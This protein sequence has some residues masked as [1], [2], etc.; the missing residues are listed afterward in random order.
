[1]ALE[2]TATNGKFDKGRELRGGAGVSCPGG[3]EGT[4]S[5]MKLS[6]PTPQAKALS[7]FVLGPGI[8][9]PGPPKGKH[10]R[11]VCTCKQRSDI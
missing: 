5:A 10:T 1:M 7:L 3:Y 8:P 6:L 2:A 11:K 9:L 4:F